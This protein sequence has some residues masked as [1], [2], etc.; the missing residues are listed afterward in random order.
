MDP[1]A[2]ITKTER[3]V[4][5]IDKDLIQRLDRVARDRFEGNRSYAVRKA[6]KELTERYEHERD[7]A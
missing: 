4:L 5:R 7:A 3:L 1:Q 6:L 2:G